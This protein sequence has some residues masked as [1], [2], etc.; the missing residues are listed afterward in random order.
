MTSRPGPIR[1]SFGLLCRAVGFLRNLVL[2]L[3][4]LAIAAALAFAWW[5]DGTPKLEPD[6]ALVLDLSGPIVEQRRS[7]SARSSLV[8]VLAERE[9]ERETLLPEVLAALDAAA[10]DPKIGRV[11]LLL[12]DMEGAG[13]ATLREVADAIGRVRAGGKQVIAWGSALDQRRYFLAAHADQ[14]LLHPFG[15]VV[16]QGFGGYRNYY[17]DALETVGVTVNVFKV[18]RYKSAVE[19]FSRSGP[20]EEARR[21]EAALLGDLWAQYLAAVEGARKLPGGS[22][23]RLIDQLPERFA[24]AGGDSARLA[25]EQKLVD[26]LQTRDELRAMMIDKGTA[27]PKH[28]TFRQIGLTQYLATLPAGE[29]G[30]VG[31]VV[32][33]GEMLDGDRQPGLVGGRSTAALIRRA[34]EDESIK[35]VVLRV[36]SPGG[37]VFAAEQIRH[38]LEVTRKAGKP[39][40]VSFGDV[41]ASGGYWVSMSADEV[42]AD[43]ATITGSI[44]VFALLPS[45]DRTWEKLSLHAHGT[46]TTWLAGALD[47]RRPL[48]PRARDLLQTG[49]AHIY[50]EFVGRTAAAR[51]LTVEQVDELAQGRVWSGRQAHEH[52]LVDRLGGYRDTLQ[53]AAKRGGLGERFRVAYIER[54]PRGIERVLGTLFGEVSLASLPALDLLQAGAAFAPDAAQA[55]GAD[56]RWL[57]NAARSPLAPQSHCLCSAEGLWGTD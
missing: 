43:P 48:D 52:R 44:G 32:A 57:R 28:K 36:R 51:R 9:R 18:G 4:F 50:R 35:A 41:A 29:G 30:A 6:T 14:V 22:I 1:R 46:T 40:L 33:S 39:V 7:S 19:P 3:L 21:D 56:L 38:E 15:R 10:T 31:V 11:L 8:Q 42:L 17:G 55:I 49:V 2:N 37:S 53:A 34:R 47:P 16:L 25:L 26:G 27:D 20:S 24:A 45:V 23:A 13:L 54:E 12:D 5:H